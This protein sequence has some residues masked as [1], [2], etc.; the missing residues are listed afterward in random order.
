MKYFLKSSLLVVITLVFGCKNEPPL[1]DQQAEIQ[2]P[3]TAVASPETKPL[4]SEFKSYWYQGLAEIT[5]FKLSQE[6]YGELH[7]GT[8]VQIYVTEDFLPD[9]QVKAETSSSS[10]IPVLKLNAT[11]KFNTG[12]YPY[13]IMES[14][15]YPVSRASHALKISASIQEWCGQVYTQVNNRDSLEVQSHSYFQG[16]ADRQFSLEKTCMENELW[17]LLRIHPESLPT[18]TFQIL[19]SLEY[20]QLRHVPIKT[21]EV[22]ASLESDRY[23]LTYPSLERQLIIRFNPEFPHDILGWQESIVVGFGANQS[24]MTTKAQRINSIKTA[25]WSHNTN[26]DTY[27]RDELGLE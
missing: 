5:S 8:A 1:D 23:T 13:S 16:E 6:R 7:E 26:T 14:T 17:N 9:S 21:Y 10:N 20:L 15:F 27:L 24:I 19:P 2:P 11:K 4:S 25:Y 22:M 18:G 3:K 12:I